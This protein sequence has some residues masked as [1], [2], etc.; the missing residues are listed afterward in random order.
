MPDLV[1][2]RCDTGRCGCRSLPSDPVTTSATP[3]CDSAPRSR[4]PSVRAM[5]PTETRITATEAMRHGCSPLHPGYVVS[6][7]LTV[8]SGSSGNVNVSASSSS[9]FNDTVD[10][11]CSGLPV[12]AV[13]SFAPASVSFGTATSATSTLTITTTRS[14]MLPLAQWQRPNRLVRYPSPVVAFSLAACILAL[15]IVL[16]MRRRFIRVPLAFATVLLLGLMMCVCVGCGGGPRPSATYTVQV[17]ATVHGGTPAVSH[18]ATM[19]LIVQR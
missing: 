5:R 13:C 7:S 12:N 6:D 1:E 11:S 9:G 14:A 19:T 10:L 18:S 15:F 4:H 3:A 8:T 16:S 17:L 2:Q